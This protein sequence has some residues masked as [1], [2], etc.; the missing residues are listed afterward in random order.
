MNLTQLEWVKTELKRRRYGLNK[1]VYFYCIW[2][3][4]FL[5]KMATKHIM[6]SRDVNKL[7]WSSTEHKHSI[8]LARDL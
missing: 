1:L 5:R 2:R 4:V 6:T 7:K 3:F 8:R